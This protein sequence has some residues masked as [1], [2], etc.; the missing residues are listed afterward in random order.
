MDI[1]SKKP[2]HEERFHVNVVGLG[3]VICDLVKT[4]EGKGH[5]VVNPNLVE[6]AVCLLSKLDHITVIETFIYKSNENEGQET[7]GQET[8]GRNFT[9]MRKYHNRIKRQL[10]KTVSGQRYL[11]D[12]GSGRGGDVS[13]WR[14]FDKIVAVEPN[15]DHI[16]E[17]ERRLELW[18]LRDRV[19]IVQTGGEDTKKI[20][21]AVKRFVGQRVHIISMMLSM[22]FFWKNKKRLQKLVETIDTN[23][24]D[25]G[26]IL[27]MVM[28]G[29]T[30]EEVF[31]PY[32]LSFK[33][34]KLVFHQTEEDKG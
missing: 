32:F 29:D 12:I 7:E 14:N 15:G 3:H 27:F 24:D 17:L 16:V 33:T 26:T 25:H 2:S 1:D 23:L 11:L 4:V 10:F 6:L 28:D 13:K 21:A 34:R 19:E 8:E 30:V 5:T 20:T 22:T 31:D 18:G 9:L